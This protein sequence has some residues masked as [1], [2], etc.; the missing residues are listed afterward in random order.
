MGINVLILFRRPPEI[1]PILEGDAQGDVMAGP[2]EDADA[3]HNVGAVPDDEVAEFMS[4]A[5]Q[6][7]DQGVVEGDAL[8][9]PS[10]VGDVD[11][12]VGLLP[13]QRQQPGEDFLHGPR[14]FSQR[15][16]PQITCVLGV[17]LDPEVLLIVAGCT[18]ARLV[19]PPREAGPQE[20]ERSRGLSQAGSSS[21]SSG[22]VFSAVA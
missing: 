12:A 3:I 7:F 20:A 6:F 15:Q 17:L 14:V 16:R 9:L 21:G 1:Q 22:A 18:P 10:H 13:Q 11:H 4:D 19:L 2:A 8:I 5:P